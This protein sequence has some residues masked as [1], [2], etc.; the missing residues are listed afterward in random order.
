MSTRPPSGRDPADSID[1]WVDALAGRPA[2]DGDPIASAEGRQLREGLQRERDRSAVPPG[3]ESTED[4]ERLLQ[5]GRAAGLS[6]VERRGLAAWCAGCARRWQ[7]LLELVRGA[8]SRHP[9]S[10]GGA[11][12]LALAGLVALGLWVP[13][14]LSVPEGEPETVLRGAPDGV[15]TRTAADPAAE[16]DRLADAL[17]A[18]GATVTRYERLGRFGLEADLPASRSPEL[19]QVLRQAGILAGPDGSLRVE[20]GAPP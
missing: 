5:R 7:R 3:L 11:G 16:R 15:W 20:F 1:D 10:L 9:L 19:Q 13:T 18:T 8:G 12:G 2:S 17:A 6:S 4:L 14:L